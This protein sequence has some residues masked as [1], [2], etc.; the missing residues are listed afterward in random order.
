[1]SPAKSLSIIKSPYRILQS[2]VAWG[3]GVA[4]LKMLVAVSINVDSR[5]PGSE[6]LELPVWSAALGGSGPLEKEEGLGDA[7]GLLKLACLPSF[8]QQTHFGISTRS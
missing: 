1:M 3:L 7:A 8:I 5:G 6:V 2:Q 4:S